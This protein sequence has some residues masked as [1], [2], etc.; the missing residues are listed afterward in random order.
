MIH[1]ELDVPP[2]VL[3]QLAA[4]HPERYPVLFD[5]AADGPLSCTSV[6]VAS[7]TGALW[8]DAQ[9]RLHAQGAVPRHVMVPAEGFVCALERWIASLPPQP[10]ALPFCGGWAIF[11]GYELAGEIEPGL[12]LPA[13]PASLPWQAFALRVPCALVHD[14]LSGRVQ[15]IAEEGAAQALEQVE[16]DALQLARAGSGAAAT[17]APLEVARII[18]EEPA[19]Y[20]ERV[21][22]GKEYIRAGDIYQT[23]LSRPWRIELRHEAD[24]GRLHERLRTANPA[25][26]AALARWRGGVVLSSSPERLVRV[27]GRRVETRP[28]AGTRP[29]SRQP[30]ED[31]RETAALVAHPKERAEHIMLIDLERNDLGRVCEP[32]TVRVE[33][34]MSIESYAHVHHIVSNV[35]GV[36]RS[37]VTSMD[38]L[39]AVFPGGTITGCPKYRCMEIIAEL[40]GE[41]R[42]AYTGSLGLLGRDGGM[43]FNILIRTMTLAGRMI[44]FRAG[45]GIVADSDPERELEETRAKA[46]GLLAAFAEAPRAGA[47]A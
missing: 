24:V 13:P 43:D 47:A 42:G 26:F 27:A 1:R 16:R 3:R 33:E 8:L 30:G 18:E 15:A 22:R 10:P 36:L 21:R 41:G 29:R 9:G 37:D 2:G 32:G 6:L 17:P 12:A 14:R 5:S 44:E 31:A 28:I 20:L 40:E 7:P 38:V 19:A 39:R 25:P 11:L 23:N 34:L 4:S 45:A 46:R 35:T